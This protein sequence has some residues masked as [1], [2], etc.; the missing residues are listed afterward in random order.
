MAAA[1]ALSTETLCALYASSG[2]RAS[3]H[4]LFASHLFAEL[5]VRQIHLRDWR[6]PLP[7]THVAGVRT[8]QHHE[9]TGVPACRGR[10]PFKVRT[11]ALRIERSPSRSYILTCQFYLALPLR[12]PS[13]MRFLCDDRPGAVCQSKPGPYFSGTFRFSRVAIF[14]NFCAMVLLPS[15][16]LEAAER[17]QWVVQLFSVELVVIEPHF[18]MLTLKRRS[19][20]LLKCSQYNK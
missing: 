4:A 6:I 2:I 14:K 7:V 9:R 20:R 11:R 19:F 13:L 5:K 1:I 8:C 15:G 17:S 18:K 3:S 16:A 10:G 12:L